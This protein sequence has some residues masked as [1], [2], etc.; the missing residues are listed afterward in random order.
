MV[1]SEKKKP[2]KQPRKLTLFGFSAVRQ[3]GSGISATQYPAGHEILP[4][5]VPYDGRPLD[6]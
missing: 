1:T 5:H 6:D 4:K 2:E 3:D